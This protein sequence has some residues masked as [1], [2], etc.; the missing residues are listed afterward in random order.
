MMKCNQCG[1][2]ITTRPCLHCGANSVTF[3][4]TVSDG[5]RIGDSVDAVIVSGVSTSFVQGAGRVKTINFDPGVSSAQIVTSS[6]DNVGLADTIP[7]DVQNQ[8]VYNI[9]SIESYVGN[10]PAGETT[11]EYSFEVNL[12]IVKFGWKRSIKKS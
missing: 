4:E 11:E 8:L 5:I 10:P 7:R 3:E 1:R 9:N 12:G 6:L 2:I